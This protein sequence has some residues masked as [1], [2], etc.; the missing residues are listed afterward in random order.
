M[1]TFCDQTAGIVLKFAGVFPSGVNQ[2]HNAIEEINNS[3]PFKGSSQGKVELL[4]SKFQSDHKSYLVEIKI[5][6]EVY[7]GEYGGERKVP[8]GALTALFNAVGE[9]QPVQE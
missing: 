8:Q 2:L 5:P 7:N 3:I 4:S 6:Y 9:F 1:T